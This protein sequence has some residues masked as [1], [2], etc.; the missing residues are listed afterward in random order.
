MRPDVVEA[1]PDRIVVI[2]E[3]DEADP[4]AYNIYFE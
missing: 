2:V 3:A 1:C 4:I